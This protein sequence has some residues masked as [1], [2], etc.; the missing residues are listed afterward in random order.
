MS[1]LKTL[2]LAAL[3]AASV[4]AGIQEWIA[5]SESQT[6][7][8][9]HNV[10]VADTKWNKA[11]DEKN[12]VAS[13]SQ[14][15]K[16]QKERMKHTDNYK[17]IIWDMSET[18]KSIDEFYGKDTATQKID[19]IIMSNRDFMSLSFDEQKNL[20][21]NTFSEYIQDRDD[22]VKSALIR[23]LISVV[24]AIALFKL[25]VATARGGH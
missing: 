4:G 1:K 21:E 20:V 8:N 5:R 7:N 13:A 23:T 10:L 2:G 18:I 6:S 25:R 19:D 15:A 22:S 9:L 3:T 12:Y 14:F 16:A 11:S 24:A 17:E